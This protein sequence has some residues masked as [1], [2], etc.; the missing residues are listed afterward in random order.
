MPR[1]KL[2]VAFVEKV[3]PP[4]KGRDEHFDALLPGFALRV[5]DSGAKSYCAFYRIGDRLR[6]YTIGNA[7]KIELDA[8]RNIAREAFA[9][10]AKGIDL[11]AQKRQKPVTPPP[12]R[13][14]EEQAREYIR[15]HVSGKRTAARIGADI[16]RELIPK[17]KGRLVADISRADVVEL[18][19]R[20]ADRGTLRM[21]DVIK[22]VISSMWGW[23][24]E[25][26]VA[27][28]NPATGIRSIGHNVRTRVLHD[29]EIREI[30]AAGE[31][32]PYPERE[33]AQLLLL[34]GQRTAQVA[35]MAWADISMTKRLWRVPREISKTDQPLLVP[36][37]DTAIR[38]LEAVPKFEG[39]KFVLSY[40]AG[41]RPFKNYHDVKQRLDQLSGVSGWTWHDM[42][43]SMRTNLSKLGINSDVAERVIGHLPG[44][45]KGIYDQH[46][47]EPEMRRALDA[48]DRRLQVIAR[49]GGGKNVSH[50]HQGKLA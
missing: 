50:I 27:T 49:D 41:K 21:R 17:W 37:S 26:G 44:G 6:R 31:Q 34:T 8:A 22:T 40:H 25:R 20:I 23:F 13:L 36:L 32:L 5:T 15:R 10:A 24:I 12:E 11:A 19:D 7:E 47:F 14:F 2:T 46:S 39:G 30:W 1:K 45:V 9:L 28:T 16:E 48:W 4:A 42:R 29:G 38:L 43:R 3:S 18:L 35:Q 33:F